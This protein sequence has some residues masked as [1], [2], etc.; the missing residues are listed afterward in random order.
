[1]DDNALKQVPKFKYVGN[2]ITE[3]GENKE[4][5]YNEL[6]I[7]KLCLIIKRNYCVRITLVW[8]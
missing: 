1:M 8:K 2:I 5:K 3:D 6:K 7:I 4:D